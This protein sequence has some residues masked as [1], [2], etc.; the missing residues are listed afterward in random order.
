MEILGRGWRRSALPVWP[1]ESAAGSSAR[2]T[3][4]CLHAVVLLQIAESSTGRSLGV[5][6]GRLPNR[7]V[8]KRCFFCGCGG[9]H[10]VFN[11]SPSSSS[12]RASFNCWLRGHFLPCSQ[13]LNH[14]IAWMWNGVIVEE[15][16]GFWKSGS[17][18]ALKAF[19]FPC[20]L[21]ACTGS[22]WFFSAMLYSR[23]CWSISSWNAS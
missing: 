22:F 16:G 7:A 10:A 15:E 18:R 20:E 19:S 11:F 13:L 4:S 5:E 21:S 1:R 14:S 12:R 2:S 8:Q 23:S 3:D 9:F 6:L 17:P